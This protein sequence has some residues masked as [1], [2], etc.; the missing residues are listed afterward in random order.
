[1]GMR[2]AAI[3]RSSVIDRIAYDTASTTLRISFRDTGDYL[4]FDVPAD[5]FDRFHGAESAGSFF[6]EF[7]RGRYRYRRDPV[8]RK[9]APGRE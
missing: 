6:N 4:Y 3:D 1:M 2:A 7:I 5:L 9:F 8:R